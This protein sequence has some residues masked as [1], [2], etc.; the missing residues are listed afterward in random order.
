M[1]KRLLKN[2]LIKNP[3]NNLIIILFISISFAVIMSVTFT[4]W[5]LFNS[6]SSLYDIANPPHFLQLHKGD[7]NIEEI[8]NFNKGV[9]YLDQSQIITMINAFGKDFKVIPKDKERR[10]FNLEN[11]SLDIFLVTQNEKFD[12]LLDA[13]KNIIN[14]KKGEI[15]LPRVLLE[16][17]DIRPGDNIIYK[18]P[19]EDIT[20]TVTDLMYD[21]QMN[22]RMAGSVRFLIDESDFENII[23]QNPEV[24]YMIEARL[25]DSSF[26]NEYQNIYEQA[27]LA[28]NG[29]AITYPL[30]ITI[31]AFT[32]I[33]NSLMF[34]VAGFVFIFISYMTLKYV[35]QIEIEEDRLVIGNMKAIGIP[36]KKIRSLYLKKFSILT[37]FGIVMGSFLSTFLTSFLNRRT[38]RIF[39][40]ASVGFMNY[41]L[42]L[43]VAILMYVLIR[44][45]IKYILRKIKYFTV[46]DILVENKSFEKDSKNKKI[47][48]L[49]KLPSEL[50]IGLQNARN[51]YGIIIFLVFA[52]SLIIIFSSRVT[53]V[54]KAD[55]FINFMGR[56]KHTAYLE[57]EPIE[58][59]D[60]IVDEVKN[61]L[62]D[63]KGNIEFKESSVY[64]QKI[65]FSK[66]PE[67]S[68]YLYLEQGK[69]VGNNLNFL[70]GVPPKEGE[71]EIAISYLLANEL[72]LELNDKI[73]IS[74]GDLTNDFWIRGIY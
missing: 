22:T 55:E 44:L 48:R 36:Y 51:G 26:A 9:D 11:F 67:K 65:N 7:L 6:I 70:Y 53:R 49:A 33:L 63:Y 61:I 1:E 57:L 45:F 41:I 71:K 32:D 34:L 39:G 56:E 24:E 66:H 23:I 31:S 14:L 46:I 10:E 18:S 47:K 43:S 59:H 27:G 15:A 38:E 42:G 73:T 74:N 35:L 69:G 64:R 2:E 4:F 60:K 40:K 8:D 72:D 28:N 58:N 5:N 17:Y 20:F 16:T 62:A 30:I 50:A 68:T 29:Q 12:Y 3:G 25:L 37:V 21:A 19:Y 54:F 13:N 52:T